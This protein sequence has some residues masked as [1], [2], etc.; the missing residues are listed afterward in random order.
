M[1]RDIKAPWAESASD[2]LM[3]AAELANLPENGRGYE[4]VEGRLVRMP[5]TG[6]WH[7][8][9]SM[10]LGT[11]LNIYVKAHNA[12][13]V[14]GAETG[15]LVSQPGAPDTVLA[16]DVAFVAR[17]RLPTANDPNLSGY[18]RIV[19]DLVVEVAS[20]TQYSPE[21]AAKA[22]QWLIAGAQLVWIVWP[23]A[24]RVDVWQ[25][26]TDDAAVATLGV[27]NTLDCQ[28]IPTLSSFTISLDDL[29]SWPS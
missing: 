12:G 16:P 20:P 17:Q 4:L 29:F 10:D 22:Q 27:G 9:I 13:M 6:G 21:M 5:P 18:W 1:A 2:R 15:F 26:G 3:S 28:S 24:K 8:R 14:L 25:Q 19:P 7:G 11:A 23:A